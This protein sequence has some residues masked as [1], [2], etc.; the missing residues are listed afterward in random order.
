VDAV[1][2]LRGDAPFVVDTSAWW[3]FS[4]LPSLST[5]GET[6]TIEVERGR[7]VPTLAEIQPLAHA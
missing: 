7:L 4:E 6:L 1:E 5:S 3:R 2:L